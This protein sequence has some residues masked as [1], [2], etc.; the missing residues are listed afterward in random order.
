MIKANQGWNKMGE[1]IGHTITPIEE[2]VYK[3]LQ[4]PTITPR[5]KRKNPFL[6]EENLS[7]ENSFKK[8]DFK[9]RKPFSYFCYILAAV[10]SSIMVHFGKH[11]RSYRSKKLSEFYETRLSLKETQ[12]KCLQTCSF[13]MKKKVEILFRSYKLLI[14]LW[15]FSHRVF[16]NLRLSK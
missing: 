13:G 16:F 15:R 14:Q 4:G 10:F 12:R 7:V 6:T 5:K 2:E 1:Y 8:P 11:G 3:I 9:N